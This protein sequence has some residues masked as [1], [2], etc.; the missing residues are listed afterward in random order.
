[1]ANRQNLSVDVQFLKFFYNPF[2]LLTN[3]TENTLHNL[4][5][6][7]TTL[8]GMALMVANVLCETVM[9]FMNT[10]DLIDALYGIIG[11]AISFVYLIVIFMHGLVLVEEMNQKNNSENSF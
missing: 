3:P 9:G 8:L 10:T 7:Y 4:K 2:G 11:V 5:F 1:M 6:K